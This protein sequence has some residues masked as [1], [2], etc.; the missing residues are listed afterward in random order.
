VQVA[1]HPA[2]GMPRKEHWQSLVFVDVGITHR[3]SIHHQRVV[4]QRAVAVGRVLELLDE[5]G[6]LADVVGVQLCELEDRLGDFAVMLQRVERYLH[7]AVG[8]DT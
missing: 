3:A 5:V 7:T 6:G 1:L 4:E 8:V 2:V